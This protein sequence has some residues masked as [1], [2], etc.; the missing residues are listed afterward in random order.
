MRKSMSRYEN[1]FAQLEAHQEGA[2][3]PFITLGDPSM[4]LSEETIE[5]L[6]AG[7]AN[8]LELG[9]PFSDPVA[10]GP[11]IQA[12]NLRALAA[13]AKVA[14]C[15]ALLKRVRARHPDLPIGLLVYCNLVHAKGIG[16]FYAACAEAGVDSVLIADVPMRES[17][18][19]RAAARQH[20][21]APVFICPPDATTELRQQVA[22]ASEG[23]VYLLSRAGVTGTGATLSLPAHEALSELKAFASAP[24]LLG[25]GISQ[26]SHVQEAIASGA[27]GAISGSAVVSIIAKYQHQ[28]N[29][30]LSKLT[31]FTQAMKAAT[32]KY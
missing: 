7:G 31:D 20:G 10:D 11:V 12:A 30:M 25:F 15:F 9:M 8:A 17:A 13:G 28:P 27:A 1:L 14:Q 5:A 21:I 23:Y 18:S 22:A 19:Y 29:L 32:R 2:Y 6:I 16:D 24:A 3:V 4:A 26:P